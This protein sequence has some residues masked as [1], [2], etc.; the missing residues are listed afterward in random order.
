MARLK[1]AKPTGMT[2]SW[3]QVPSVK[4]ANR[5]MHM[6]ELDLHNQSVAKEQ[7]INL[8][9]NVILSQR[10]YI[11]KVQEETNKEA[12]YQTASTTQVHAGKESPRVLTPSANNLL[13]GIRCYGWKCSTLKGR[14]L[15]RLTGKVMTDLQIMQAKCS[16]KRGFKINTFKRTHIFLKTLKTEVEKESF[17]HNLNSRYKL[18]FKLCSKLFQTQRCLYMEKYIFM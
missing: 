2:G 15:T 13:A 5:K 12:S 11:Q 17:L 6:G 7:I 10:Q 1:M 3:N 9:H 18:L 8:Q 16:Q 4:P 14:I